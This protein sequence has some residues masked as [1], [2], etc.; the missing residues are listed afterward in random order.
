MFLA[1]ASGAIEGDS[2]SGMVL[3]I[4]QLVERAFFGSGDVMANAAR[5]LRVSA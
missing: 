1:M 2:G 3:S 4:L 5:I